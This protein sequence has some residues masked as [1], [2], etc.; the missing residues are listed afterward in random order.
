[1]PP[2]E[3]TI[4]YGGRR[5]RLAAYPEGDAWHAAVTER[6][7]DGTACTWQTEQP[8][9]SPAAALTHA[10]T[11]VLAMLLDDDAADPADATSPASR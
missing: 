3:T 6:L 1:M 4:T 8:Q 11:L 9:P 7:P 2:L 5:F 10:S